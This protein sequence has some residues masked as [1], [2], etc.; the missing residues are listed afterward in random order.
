MA[1]GRK[2][3][4][5]RRA[6][7]EAVAL[8]HLDAVY[9]AALTLSGQPSAADDLAQTTFA[10]ALEAFDSFQP[11]TNCRAWLMRILRN[12]WIDQLRRGRSAGSALPLDEDLAAAPEQ[13]EATAWTDARDLLENFSDQRVIEALCSLPEELRLTLY[14]ADVE[15][16]SQREVAEITGVPEGTVK[17][18]TSRARSALSR[19]LQAYAREMGFLGRRS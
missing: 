19:K 14:L 13:A 7:F 3:T 6:V 4:S 5:Q 11:G 18:R 15:H 12:A 1:W 10:K 9:R 17:S 8:P 2:L 16:L